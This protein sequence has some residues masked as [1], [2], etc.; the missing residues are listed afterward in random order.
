MELT[1]QIEDRLRTLSSRRRRVVVES[2]NLFARE[3][4]DQ[5]A[6]SRNS[7]RIQVAGRAAVDAFEVLMSGGAGQVARV[8]DLLAQ[9]RSDIPA[10]EME[11]EELEASGRLEL[12]ALYRSVEEESLKVSELEEAGI[13]R[14]RLK[15]LRDQDRLLGIKLPFQR[16]FLYPRWQFGEDL[17]PASFLPEILAAARKEG[18]DELTVHRLMTDPDAGGGTPLCA[19]CRRGEIELALNAIRTFGQSGG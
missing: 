8:S 14:Q 7:K 11:L 2:L 10:E 13:S 1:P 5:S 16:G 12:L 4:L 18:L 9:V 17:T 3:L 19:L 6:A 15:Q